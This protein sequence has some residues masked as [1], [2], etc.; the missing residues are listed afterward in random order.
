MRERFAKWV[1][2]SMG[3]YQFEQQDVLT[4]IRSPF[5]TCCLVS[6]DWCRNQSCEYENPQ[7][8]CCIDVLS[9]WSLCHV[10]SDYISL[11][12]LDSL[13]GNGRHGRLSLNWIT[14]L[15]KIMFL[16]NISQRVF[17]VLTAMAET[18]VARESWGFVEM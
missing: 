10:V 13:E 4:M 11:Q 14:Q 3:Q 16:D 8:C 12:A 17:L 5:E 18:A 1:R 6:P 9:M 7:R 15:Q 2:C